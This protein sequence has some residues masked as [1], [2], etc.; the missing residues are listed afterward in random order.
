MLFTYANELSRGQFEPIANRRRSTPISY[1]LIL[2]TCDVNLHMSCLK[3]SQL[4]NTA[5]RALG[6]TDRF[7]LNNSHGGCLWSF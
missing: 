1:W 3:V 2:V 7:T 5:I 6:Q 4:G